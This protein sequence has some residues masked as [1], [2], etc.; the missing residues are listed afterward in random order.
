MNYSKIKW[1][2]SSA[3]YYDSCEI[4]QTFNSI[5]KFF[6]CYG[7]FYN[8]APSVSILQVLL[9]IGAFLINF[10]VIILLYT[11]PIKISIFDQILIGYCLVNGITG[12]VDIPF[13]HVAYIFGYWPFG[14]IPSRLW[15][16]IEEFLLNLSL[17]YYVFLKICIKAS[18]DNNINFTTSMHMLFISWARLRSIQAPKS[19]D[20][21]LLLK[22]PIVIMVCI[23]TVGLGF[24]AS[25]SFL[26]GTLDYTIDV[27]FKPEWVKLAFNIATWFIPLFS[28][29]V[30]SVYVIYLLLVRHNSKISMSKGTKNTAERSLFSFGYSA[31]ESLQTANGKELSL[32]YKLIKKF[33][34]FHLSAQAKLTIIVTSYW[35]QW[36][37]CHLY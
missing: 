35:I 17:F 34:H 8:Q 16:I 28:I 6:K 15:V 26:F 22:K 13:Y 20:K 12:I 2:N 37:I 30:I 25:T 36:V 33:R 21:E 9:F 29:L 23:W 3:F 14:G 10:L 24:W 5:E 19:F 1:K 11:R 4:P 32:I 18:Y 31:N 7:Y 27:D